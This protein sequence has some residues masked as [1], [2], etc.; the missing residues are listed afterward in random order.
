M[1]NIKIKTVLE[2]YISVI[3]GKLYTAKQKERILR[4]ISLANGL[5][6]DQINEVKAVLNEL[7]EEELYD[8]TIC[9][10]QLLYS[11]LSENE[12]PIKCEA[13]SILYELT[14]P[15]PK[16]TQ[17]QIFGNERVWL[18]SMVKEKDYLG[19]GYYKYAKGKLSD[20]IEYFDKAAK[21]DVNIPIDEYIAI[22]SAE[23]E[24]YAKAYEYSLKAQYI[25]DD[26]IE[27]EWL[28]EIENLAKSKISE[29]EAEKILK[30]VTDSG[31]PPKIG[32]SNI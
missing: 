8:F 11:I 22:I 3:F 30:K 16:E 27:I 10:N 7:D 5:D 15:Q 19:L 28:A 18:N 4:L 12:S 2:N 6:T 25:D 21:R 14:K 23:A 26:K 29:S 13:I 24:D 9:S 20:A 31:E 32:F 17:N 1:E